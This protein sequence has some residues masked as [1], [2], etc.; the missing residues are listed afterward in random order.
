MF[1]HR[2]HH[3]G[4]LGVYFRLG[5]AGAAMGLAVMVRRRRVR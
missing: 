5:A 2:Y 1:N 4:Q 3:R